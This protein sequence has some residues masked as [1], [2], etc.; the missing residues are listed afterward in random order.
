MEEPNPKRKSGLPYLRMF[1]VPEGLKVFPTVIETARNGYQSR[2]VVLDQI[3]SIDTRME[4]VRDEQLKAVEYIPVINF[5]TTAHEYT[6]R[7]YFSQHDFESLEQ[8]KAVRD[9]I[10]GTILGNGYDY[11]TAITKALECYAKVQAQKTQE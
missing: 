9:Y 10:H 7:W 4:T 2:P 11:R 6:I 1:L 3:V 5:I 8:A